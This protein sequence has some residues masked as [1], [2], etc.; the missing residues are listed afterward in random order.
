MCGLLVCKY[1]VS[2]LGKQKNRFAG[3]LNERS[4]SFFRSSKFF[5]F[6][7]EPLLEFNIHFPE[8]N[9]HQFVLYGRGKQT[10]KCREKIYFF[11]GKIFKFT[12]EH[13]HEPDQ[14]TVG[15]YEK[16]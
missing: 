14:S 3:I 11:V 16:R 7:R 1:N 6:F 8:L 2:V 12:I 5:S 15:I 13:F 4:V 10:R 9:L